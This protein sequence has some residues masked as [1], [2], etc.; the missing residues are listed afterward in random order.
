MIVVTCISDLI[1]RAYASFLHCLILSPMKSSHSVFAHRI[2][3]LS[4]KK[5]LYPMI[6]SI[7]SLAALAGGFG[8]AIQMFFI[9]SL[10]ELYTIADSF[11]VGTSTGVAADFFIAASMVYLL[12]QSH[13][14]TDT[15]VNIL[16]VYAIN[17]GLF[18]TICRLMGLVAY[19]V[20]TDKYIFFGI[21][22]ILPELSLNALLA[23]LNAR[24]SLRRR[25][26]RTNAIPLGL[27][28]GSS[29]GSCPTDR[30]DSTNPSFAIQVDKQVTVSD[31]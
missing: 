12:V 2:W 18:T 10:A 26:K 4:R 21:Y 30:Q 5:V 6:I 14:G 19:A 20:W 29:S 27:S 13:T 11:Y 31:I 9:K 17:T 8:C 7:L 22:Y 28:I 3:R 24:E 1:V 16:M 15:L 25:S 23:T